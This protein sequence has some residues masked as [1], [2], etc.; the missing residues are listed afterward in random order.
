MSLY[1]NVMAV[2]AGLCFSMSVFAAGDAT[3]AVQ[4]AAGQNAQAAQTSN[5]NP[6][7]MQHGKININTASLQELMNVKGMNRL[8]AKSI[9]RY[10]SQ[11]LFKS[12]DE[13][14]SVKGF[15]R[16]NTENLKAIQEQMS[17]E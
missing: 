17:V 3:N 16:L 1:R 11:H 5:A 13:L 14:S 9:V 8:K 2:V 6:A 12:L 10:R 7:A 4:N 15:K